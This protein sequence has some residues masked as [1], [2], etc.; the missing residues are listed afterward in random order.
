MDKME[1]PLPIATLS[2]YRVVSKIGEGGMGE[3][4]LAQDKK[5]DRRVAIKVLNEQ[6]SKD[7]DKLNR[8]VREARAASALNHPNILTV[9]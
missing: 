3:V 8:F 9:Y 5:L 4:Y 7:E 1:S 6:F 2:H